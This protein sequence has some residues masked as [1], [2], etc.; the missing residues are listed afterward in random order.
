[1]AIIGTQQMLGHSSSPTIFVLFEIPSDIYFFNITKSY[2]VSALL[3]VQLAFIHL[4][5]WIPPRDSALYSWNALPLRHFNL[6]WE[7]SAFIIYYYYFYRCHYYL[8]LLPELLARPGDKINWACFH[9]YFEFWMGGE[10][11]ILCFLVRLK[12]LKANCPSSLS[13]CVDKS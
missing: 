11:N 6:S 7:P 4:S 13:T 2:Y 3:E 8:K 12:F 9:L 1:M 5:N 10:R